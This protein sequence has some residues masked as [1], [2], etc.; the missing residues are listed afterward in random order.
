M[1]LSSAG[2]QSLVIRD[3]IKMCR[4]DGRTCEQT[5]VQTIPVSISHV[6]MMMRN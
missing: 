1:T 3:N 2:E 5:N 6:S 4:T